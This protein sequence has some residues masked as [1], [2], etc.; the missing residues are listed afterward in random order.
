MNMLLKGS[1]DFRA[2]QNKIWFMVAYVEQEERW[3]TGQSCESR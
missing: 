1:M 2:S 3:S